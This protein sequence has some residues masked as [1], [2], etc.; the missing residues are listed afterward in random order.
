MPSVANVVRACWCTVAVCTL[1]ANGSAQGV[2]SRGAARADAAA[3]Q[4]DQ[5]RE[6]VASRSGSERQARRARPLHGASPIASA[7]HL[8]SRRL[9]PFFGTVFGAG[10]FGRWE[11]EAPS[12][13]AG[14]AAEEPAMLASPDAVSAP[15]VRR[16]YSEPSSIQ[17]LEPSSRREPGA[18]SSATGTLRLDI[19]PPTAQVY[20]DGFYVG[21]VDTLNRGLTVSAGWHRLEFRAPGYQTPAVNVTI[22]PRRTVAYRLALRP[23]P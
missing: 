7:R 11:G 6:G 1:A 8:R 9:T 13:M 2:R 18:S 14:D 20:V 19:L 12:S 23:I 22:E 3:A 16:L 5:R 10:D 4:R 17:P 21:S 15:M